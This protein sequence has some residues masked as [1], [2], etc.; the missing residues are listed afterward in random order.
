MEEGGGQSLWGQ[1]LVG[2]D[3]EAGVCGSSIL[4]AESEF[5]DC[6]GVGSKDSN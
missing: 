3:M 2:V 6:K 1:M 5:S 4:T